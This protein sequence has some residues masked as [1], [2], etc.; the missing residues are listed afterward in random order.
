MPVLLE[1]G[2]IVITPEYVPGNGSVSVKVTN[3]GLFRGDTAINHA[4]IHGTE[5]TRV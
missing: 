3:D 1:A 4:C 5:Q 2:P